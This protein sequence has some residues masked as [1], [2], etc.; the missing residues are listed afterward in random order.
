MKNHVNQLKPPQIGELKTL[1]SV[2]AVDDEQSLREVMALALEMNGFRVLVASGGFEL[3]DR[4]QARELVTG[5]K[6]R[7]VLMT[8]FAGATRQEA[9]DFGAWGVLF[10]PFLIEDLLA[11]MKPLKV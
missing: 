9:Q 5:H 4:I 10:K 6:T 8:G 1:P 7:V 2:L 11:V 3:L